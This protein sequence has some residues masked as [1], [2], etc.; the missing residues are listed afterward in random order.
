MALAKKD[1]ATMPR[2]KR[3][4][5]VSFWV[6]VKGHL[7]NKGK[8][9]KVYSNNCETKESIFKYLQNKSKCKKVYSNI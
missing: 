6:F 8:Y 9:K 2:W 3:R 4:I 7:Q 1:T 5:Y